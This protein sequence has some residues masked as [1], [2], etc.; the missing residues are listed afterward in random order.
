MTWT[1][2]SKRSKKWFS[3]MV[4]SWMCGGIP[5]GFLHGY[6]SISNERSGWEF[7]TQKSQE[8]HVE[9]TLNCG[10]LVPSSR[11]FFP[12]ALLTLLKTRN[13]SHSRG[14]L[15]IAAGSI[16]GLWLRRGRSI[17]AQLSSL[18]TVGLQT[19]PGL[20]LDPSLVMNSWR[21][22]GRIQPGFQIPL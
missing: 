18:S 4:K 13:V 10:N 8:K 9:I 19:S 14:F 7:W 12:K 15:G 3:K 22:W 6:T 17:R 5:G 2:W 20:L 11:W 21:V 16:A 1:G